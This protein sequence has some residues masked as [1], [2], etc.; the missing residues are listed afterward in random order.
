MLLSWESGSSMAAQIYDS[1]GGQTV[2]NQFT[3]CVPNHN[4]Q[5]F[6]A[7]VDGSVA[8]PAAES[9]STSIM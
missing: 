6:K 1:G 7:Y 3:M 4:Y 5:A 2:G 8:Y 9:R